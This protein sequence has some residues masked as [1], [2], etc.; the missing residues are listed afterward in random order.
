MFV[1]FTSLWNIGGLQPFCRYSNP[2]A[3][4][5]YLER[6][7]ELRKEYYSSFLPEAASTA[8]RS[9]FS[10]LKKFLLLRLPA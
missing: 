4:S 5:I 8:I 1:D 10:Q 9:L 2:E 7:K 6:N 3:K